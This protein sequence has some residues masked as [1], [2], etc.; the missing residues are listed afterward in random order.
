MI[1]GEGKTGVSERGASSRAR[2]PDRG[3]VQRQGRT[4]SCTSLGQRCSRRD[5]PSRQG[6]RQPAEGM[7]G[8]TSQLWHLRDG[9]RVS[10]T[11]RRPA[12]KATQNVAAHHADTGAV[13]LHRA[14]PVG[15]PATPELR[16]QVRSPGVLWNLRPEAQDSEPGVRIPP[17]PSQLRY[18]GRAGGLSGPASLSGEPL[19][20]SF[21]ESRKQPW[22]SVLGVRCGVHVADT[23]L[24]ERV[25]GA[26]GLPARKREGNGAQA[27]GYVG[28]KGPRRLKFRPRETP[29]HSF[30]P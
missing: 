5:V 29:C 1:Y 23:L 2:G 20:W 27:E 26:A 30:P 28:L 17:P 24:T 4:S 14:S 21:R 18:S 8:A 6:N 22:F 13:A 10:D 9:A 12:G 25:R 7:R 3:H 19:S 11:P 15:T 16:A